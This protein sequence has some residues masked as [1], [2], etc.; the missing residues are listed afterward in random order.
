MLT[1]KLHRNNGLN[2]QFLSQNSYF[3]ILVLFCVLCSAAKF[4]SVLARNNE[5]EYVYYIVEEETPQTN[6]F[7]G[8]ETDQVAGSISHNG[9]KSARH[10]S[11]ETYASY[12]DNPFAGKH[13]PEPY[14][15]RYKYPYDP[16]DYYPDEVYPVHQIHHHKKRKRSANPFEPHFEPYTPPKPKHS[17]SSY[18]DHHFT[19]KYNDPSAYGERPH[20]PSHD[21]P[22]EHNN[23]NAYGSR[24]EY[25]DH[26]LELKYNNPNI[27]KQQ[28]HHRRK[29]HSSPYESQQ[30]ASSRVNHGSSTHFLLPIHHV[31]K[32]KR[33]VLDDKHY[34]TS[35]KYTAFA[36]N[37]FAKK[38]EPEPEY[39]AYNYGLPGEALHAR[40]SR[41]VMTNYNK[42]ELT[43]EYHQPSMYEH[44]SRF[45]L[46]TM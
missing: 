34:E 37:P 18:P 22:L 17:H 1:R 44:L 26:H 16:H 30:Q 14:Y 19:P 32:H 33:N 35:N 7:G 11:S 28:P 27:Y 24:P 6:L 46:N 23:P 4:K 40:L 3:Q 10:Y 20:Y 42:F 9:E 29:R 45:P 21:F 2:H 5:G 25:P 38:H 12:I 36:D 8:I 15:T 13:E 43:P 41:K 39:N 31:G